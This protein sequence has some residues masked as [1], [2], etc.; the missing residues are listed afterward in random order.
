MFGADDVVVTIFPKKFELKNK[1]K[2]RNNKTKKLSSEW[3]KLEFELKLDLKLVIFCTC[4]PFF[5]LFFTATFDF[6]ENFQLP[7]NWCK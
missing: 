7:T 5:R 6:Q 3:S 4:L 1:T 2:M